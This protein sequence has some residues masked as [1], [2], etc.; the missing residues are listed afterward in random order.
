MM[1]QQPIR[2]LART[3]PEFG[4][5]LIF[6]HLDTTATDFAN[7]HQHLTLG[8]PTSS[9]TNLPQDARELANGQIVLNAPT[10]AS[11]PIRLSSDVL[12]LGRSI[13]RLHQFR[14]WIIT[15]STFRSLADA[16]IVTAVG[17][18]PRCRNPLRICQWLDT[19]SS[20]AKPRGGSSLIQTGK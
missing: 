16:G 7:S 18:Y 3:A 12:F 1:C 2:S 19:V 8:H 6:P 10:P 5:P 20:G 9:W 15:P 13:D 14:A 4:L 11:T 17:F